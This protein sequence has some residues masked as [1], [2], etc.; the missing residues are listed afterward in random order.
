[1]SDPPKKSP[2]DRSPFSPIPSRRKPFVPWRPPAQPQRRS[3]SRVR[4]RARSSGVRSRGS[5]SS[6]SR[7]Q[8]SRLRGCSRSRS[9]CLNERRRRSQSRCSR[10]GPSGGEIGGEVAAPEAAAP[11]QDPLDR[12]TNKQLR[13][14]LTESTLAL[15]VG[16]LYRQPPPNPALQPRALR[17][18]ARIGL[19]S[20]ACCYSALFP[21]GPCSCTPHCARTSQAWVGWASSF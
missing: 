21:K 10:A 4:S 7:S 6:R 1:M 14:A 9:S 13:L 5:R 8:G 18:P 19:V 3:R 15:P 20:A 2:F 17:A 16:R 11:L 12:L